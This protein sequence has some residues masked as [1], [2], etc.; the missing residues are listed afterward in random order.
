MF[1]I[2]VEY[3]KLFICI[4]YITVEWSTIPSE[5]KSSFNLTCGGMDKTFLINKGRFLLG[6]LLFRFFAILPK[7]KP[8]T[9]TGVKQ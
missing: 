7:S 3:I 5:F 4:V 6:A 2:I 1:C 8:N 9:N